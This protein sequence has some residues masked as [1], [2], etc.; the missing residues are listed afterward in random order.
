[1]QL[2]PLYAKVERL[3]GPTSSEK[4]AQFVAVGKLITDFST[5][6]VGPGE[7]DVVPGDTLN[8]DIGVAVEFEEEE[9]ASDN[10]LDE[11]GGL[12]KLTNS[13]EPHSA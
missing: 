4:F 8:D 1:M 3:M 12:Y 9:D 10:E 2:V 13:V 11:V 6:G 7:G 5:G